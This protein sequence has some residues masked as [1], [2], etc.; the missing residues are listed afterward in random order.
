MTYNL[1]KMKEIMR[2]LVERCMGVTKNI[3]LNTH[4]VVNPTKKIPLLHVYVCV[5]I[6]D[7]V[8]V[9]GQMWNILDVTQI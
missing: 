2:S 9:Q 1:M 3:T 7:D 8:I 6:S 5:F 4:Q